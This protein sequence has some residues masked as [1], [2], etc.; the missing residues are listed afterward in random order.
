M[1]KRLIPIVVMIFILGSGYAFGVEVGV[2]G[3]A[4]SKKIDSG[5]HY[6][7]A[8]TTGFLVPMVKFEFEVYKMKENVATVATKDK[9]LCVGVKLRPKLGK[10]APY[11]IIG[12][13]GEFDSFG[14]VLGDYHKFTF[15]GGGCHLFL[16]DMLS[17][18]ADIRYMHFSDMNKTR[19]SAGAFLHI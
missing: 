3:G 4:M 2:T 5:F 1:I 9:T 16:I 8:L 12:V 10:F 6:G 14:L 13:G 15:F 7:L 19:F 11:A 18:R 17:I